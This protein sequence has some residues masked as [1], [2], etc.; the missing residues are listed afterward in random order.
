[1]QA[2]IEHSLHSLT[3]HG[4]QS[5][6]TP[7]TPLL[8]LLFCLG[9]KT[10]RLFKQTD[11]FGVPLRGRQPA[12]GYTYFYQ[13]M[14]EINTDERL[15]A[16]PRFRQLPDF[17]VRVASSEQSRFPP[18]VR[19]HGAIHHP[20]RDG[21]GFVGLMCDPAIDNFTR[22]LEEV[23]YGNSTIFAGEYSQVYRGSF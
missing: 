6:S 15:Q 2:I 23:L 1:L 18:D 16:G 13:R 14:V 19:A 5:Q 10:I 12:R 4:H 21:I 9:I 11:C 17:H 8:A 20:L 3:E 7:F 22:L